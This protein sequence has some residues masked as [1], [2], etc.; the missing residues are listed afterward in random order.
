MLIRLF[1]QSDLKAIEVIHNAQ[2]Q[3]EFKLPD[4]NN[5]KFLEVVVTEND[6]GDIISAAGIR[7]IAEVVAVTNKNEPVK[8]RREALYKTMQALILLGNKHGIDQ[9]HAFIQDQKWLKH[10]LRA[11]FEPCKGNAIFTNIS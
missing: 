5:N 10:L 3:T 2:Y 11:G 4:F 7:F 6:N 1:Q 9:L 8:V